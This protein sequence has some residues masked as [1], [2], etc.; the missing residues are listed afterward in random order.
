M[1]WKPPIIGCIL[2]LYI[3]LGMD[4]QIESIK[5]HKWTMKMWMLRNNE[6]TIFLEFM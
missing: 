4:S 1:V 2:N 3:L 5:T 6:V